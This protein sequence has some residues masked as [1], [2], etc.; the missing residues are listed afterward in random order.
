MRLVNDFMG[1]VGAVGAR[2]GGLAGVPSRASWRKPCAGTMRVNTDAALLGDAGVG[3]GVVIR[4]SEGMVHAMVVRRILVHW[5]AALAEAMAA[6]F[7]LIIARRLGLMRVELEVDALNVA[8]ALHGR[9][10]GRAP[11]DL[12]LEDTSVL[13]DG[14]ISFSISHVKRGGN[15]VAHLAARHMPSNGFEQLYVDA[16]PQGVLALA[17]IDLD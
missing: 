4:D 13:G 17:E 14:F 8:K 15:T 11:I 7:G 3:L 9:S 5:T 1:Y 10:F 2:P 16:F 6:K 12:I